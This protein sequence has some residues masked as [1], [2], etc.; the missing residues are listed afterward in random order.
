MDRRAVGPPDDV[1][2]LFRDGVWWLKCAIWRKW[3]DL[4]GWYLR[5]CDE[6][7]DRGF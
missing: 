3:D 1:M 4:V 5:W 7:P 2:T 6:A